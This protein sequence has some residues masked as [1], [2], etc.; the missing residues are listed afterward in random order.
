MPPLA[1]GAAELHLPVRR[2]GLLPVDGIDE[3]AVARRTDV[4]ILVRLLGGLGALLGGREDRGV[5][6]DDLDRPAGREDDAPHVVRGIRLLAHVS[7]SGA[8]CSVGPFIDLA[9]T[10]L[11]PVAR[12]RTRRYS[13]VRSPTPS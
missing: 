2:G 4:E 3:A 5:E 13:G 9:P 7:G 1:V 12:I 10:E 11:D 8:T 6:V